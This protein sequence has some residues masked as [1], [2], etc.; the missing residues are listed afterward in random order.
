M[1]NDQK[2]FD[3]H[4]EYLGGLYPHDS[5]FTS[6][7]NGSVNDSLWIKEQGNKFLKTPPKL[8]VDAI[9]NSSFGAFASNPI[10][11]NLGIIGVNHG[12]NFLMLDV[13]LRAFS[14]KN[15]FQDIG[16]PTIEIND[17]PT[18]RNFYHDANQLYQFGNLDYAPYE[19]PIPLDPVRKYYAR[20][21]ATLSLAF[22]TSHEF[23]HI[24]NGHVFFI[25]DKTK[26]NFS[27][28]LTSDNF[29]LN[30]EVYQAFEMDA[31][32]CALCDCAINVLNRALPMLVKDMNEKDPYWK[33]F[34]GSYEVAL[35]NLYLAI[36]MAFKL[37]GDGNYLPENID[38]TV[39][40]GS[41]VRTNMILTTL[42]E[43]IKDVNSKHGFNISS[44]E[45]LDLCVRRTRQSEEAYE[46]ITGRSINWE[47]RDPKNVISHPYYLRVLKVWEE[48]KYELQPY[49]YIKLPGVDLKSH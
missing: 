12:T 26:K 43:F 24:M 17:R 20:N 1:T 42:D 27:Y 33:D 21:L 19:R 11:K 5:T 34:Y 7:L 8:I 28:G 32:S 10:G 31:D 46:V 30:L 39:H 6:F 23:Y 45:T 25:S 13:F 14:Y 47:A 15:L 3:N 29:P 37:M 16:N 36:Y 48:I 4:F 40:T 22:I 2:L 38:K 35:S 18:L 44:S 9:N 41:V 49:A